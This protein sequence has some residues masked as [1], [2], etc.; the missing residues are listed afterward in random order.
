MRLKTRMIKPRRK[1]KEEK[2]QM[3][4]RLA[5]KVKISKWQK[6]KLNIVQIHIIVQ[7]TSR[8]RLKVSTQT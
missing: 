4:T 2:T 1:E 3:K 5:E 7:F 6:T 8:K